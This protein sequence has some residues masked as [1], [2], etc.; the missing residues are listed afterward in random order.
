MPPIIDAVIK[1]RESWTDKQQPYID[2]NVL[3]EAMIAEYGVEAA[4]I[5]VAKQGFKGDYRSIARPIF[6][7]AIRRK[8]L[9]SNQQN[10][11]D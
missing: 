4:Q 7:E 8:A 3:F 11:A 1:S 10:S 5:A 6:D 2:A 9:R